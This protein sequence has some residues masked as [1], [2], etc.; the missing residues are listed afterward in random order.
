MTSRPLSPRPRVPRRNTP[1]ALRAPTAAAALLS[2][3]TFPAACRA[4]DSQL[5]EVRVGLRYAVDLAVRFEGIG[6]FP[7]A[8]KSGP[9]TMGGVNRTY[10]DGYVRVD[11]SGNRGGR[12][13]NWGYTHADQVSADGSEIAFHS[14]TAE[15]LSSEATGNTDPGP[16]VA[17][18]VRVW[19]RTRLKLKLEAGFGFNHFDISQT[20]IVTGAAV[21]ETDHYTLDGVIPPEAPYA[22]RA[23]GPGPL[24]PDRA[25]YRS[26]SS[27]ASGATVSGSRRFEADLYSFQLGP[28]LD[29][30]LTRRISLSL[31]IGFAADLVDGTFSFTETAS[32]L[33]GPSLYVQG[34]ARSTECALGAYVAGR[35]SYRVTQYWKAFVGTEYRGLQDVTLESPG[36]RES[37]CHDAAYLVSSGVS[38]E[39]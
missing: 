28:S 2:L 32:I 6:D 38:F 24:L 18:A 25:T 11:R 13:W 17:F 31:G 30:A 16:E 39:F 10:D 21:Q 14:S 37:L 22:G 27:L 3:A 9:A 4:A 26:E 7:A 35:L 5:F 33:G 29:F 15:S 12:T 8:T 23:D 34:H 20:G 1:R 19:E 36:H